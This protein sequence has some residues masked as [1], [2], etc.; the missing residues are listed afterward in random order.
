MGDLPKVLD[1]YQCVIQETEDMSVYGR[2]IFGKHP[3][4]PMIEAYIRQGMMYCL[5]ER[6]DIAATVAVTP[7]QTEDYHEID[8]QAELADDEVAVVHILAVNPR[9]QKR[10]YA[11]VLMRDVIALAGHL[12]L[13][14][15]RLDALDRNIPAHSLYESLGFQRRDV[16]RW[17]TANAGW[18]DF[19]LF[20]YL[21][22]QGTR[23]DE[24][25]EIQ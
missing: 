14:A 11:K 6:G 20:E 2:W 23:Q 7:Y 9:L 8:W 13:K 25:G 21:L 12:G 5:E 4:Q 17:H 18:I 15:V 10:G 19:Y 1:F 24:E 16:R 22:E 3:T